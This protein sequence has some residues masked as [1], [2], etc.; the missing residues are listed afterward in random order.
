MFGGVYV[1]KTLHFYVV[2]GGS[3]YKKLAFL[4]LELTL[5]KKDQTFSTCSCLEE[6]KVVRMG[7]TKWECSYFIFIHHIYTFSTCSNFYLGK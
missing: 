7:I 2:L 4:S 3:W 5:G 6:L 1:A